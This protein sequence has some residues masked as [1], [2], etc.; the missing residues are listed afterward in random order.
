M[1][2]ADELAAQARQHEK[3]FADVMS[4][5]IETYSLT[6]PNNG[7]WAEWRCR[8]KMRQT[9]RS[10]EAFIDLL[11]DAD[12]NPL[13]RESRTAATA[14]IVE[15]VRGLVKEILEAQAAAISSRSDCSAA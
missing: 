11:R 5:G 9:I 15:R 1:I 2:T 13:D 8:I 3:A 14:W 6:S 4:R 12:G 10:S 7:F